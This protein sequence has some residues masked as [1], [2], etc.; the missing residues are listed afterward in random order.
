MFEVL[1]EFNNF[2]SSLKNGFVALFL[3]ELNIK[4]PARE[5]TLNEPRFPHWSI[6]RFDSVSTHAQRSL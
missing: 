3:P 2:P 4:V 1:G 6:H 5:F